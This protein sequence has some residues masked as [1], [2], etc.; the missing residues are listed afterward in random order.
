MAATYP[1]RDWFEDTEKYRQHDN[2]VWVDEFLDLE[3]K[4]IIKDEYKKYEKLYK[5]AIA[6]NKKDLIDYWDNLEQFT[7]LIEENEAH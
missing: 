2:K 7:I 6:F 1:F 3:I 5:E 4:K